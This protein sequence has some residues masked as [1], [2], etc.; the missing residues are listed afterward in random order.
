MDQRQK[1]VEKHEEQHL[2]TTIANLDKTISDLEASVRHI[3]LYSVGG[4]IDQ[5]DEKGKK[6]RVK[7]EIDEYESYKAEP[8]YAR[9]DYVVQDNDT[10]IYIGKPGFQAGASRIIDWRT[11]LAGKFRTRRESEFVLS[12][13]RHQITLKREL[14][15]RSSELEDMQDT[16]IASPS[17]RKE[18]PKKENKPVKKVSH[19]RDT[20]IDVVP[21]KTPV[22]TSLREKTQ[23]DDLP[24]LTLDEIRGTTLSE[25]D[26]GETSPSEI[27]GDSFEITEADNLTDPFLIRLLQEK[28]TT[29][30]LTDIIRTIQE[31]QNDI[32]EQDLDKSFV[33]QGCAGSG[34]TMVLLHRISL[35]AYRHP[36]LDLSRVKIITPSKAFN[37]HISKLSKDLEI[38]NIDVFSIEEYYLELIKQG[39]LSFSNYLHIQEQRKNR[40][41]GLAD[42]KS[43]TAKS[44][45]ER[46]AVEPDPMDTKFDGFLRDIY[47]ADF[48]SYIANALHE[49]FEGKESDAQELF[50]IYE[51]VSGQSY[52]GEEMMRYS[53]FFTLIDRIYEA[54]QKGLTSLKK[55]E[56]DETAQ[57]SLKQRVQEEILKSQEAIVTLP[58]EIQGLESEVAVLAQKISEDSEQKKNSSLFKSFVDIFKQDSGA[59]EDTEDMVELRALK[60][61][62]AIKQRRLDSFKRMPEALL[63]ATSELERVRQEIELL[64]AAKLISSVDVAL[65]QKIE[66]ELDF[67]NVH[68]AAIV[69]LIKIFAKQHGLGGV[70]KFTK[71]SYSKYELFVYLT[72]ISQY[73]PTFRNKDRYLHI[74]EGQDI[75]P[76]EYELFQAINAEASRDLVVNIYG[77]TNQLITPM[78]GLTDWSEVSDT[79]KV[80]EV[81]ELNENYR[82]TVEIT[83]F[84]NK[85]FG[86]SILPVGLSGEKVTKG[87]YEDV[88]DAIADETTAGKRVAI[89]AKNTEVI[90]IMKKLFLIP[91]A[92]YLTARE[93]K[94]IEYDV[95]YV[96]D[97]GMTKNERYIACTRP[98]EK[99]VL[100]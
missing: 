16:F 85:R 60:D 61:K 77:D 75:S 3:S 63:Q 97:F 96:L 11:D 78:R 48:K 1:E 98:L 18:T 92:E 74:D 10:T 94:G 34:K 17:V 45:F 19:D 57:L 20:E 2:N 39:E 41:L 35:L 54:Q 22:T 29:R 70:I 5:Q 47:A 90:D 37:E 52:A 55:L 51:K 25:A 8:Y 93:V 99:L 67:K 13:L 59:D 88:A 49:F 69:P 12:G 62:L 58:V 82:N 64:K 87:F 66:K 46:T 79:L 53:S 32:I 83:T 43:K 56:E 73:H 27:H 72:F 7:K 86:H 23:D 38:E 95:C 89:I 14:V 80:S 40:F 9:M 26:K 15:I 6:I 4:G 81:F 100:F 33:V 42:K 36:N 30:E 21:M 68:Q 31:N 84:N 71:D 44:G 24:I 65:I 50:R 28:R 91:K 76:T